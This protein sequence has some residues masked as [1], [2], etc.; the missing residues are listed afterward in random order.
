MKRRTV[1]V[2]AIGAALAGCIGSGT[3]TADNEADP[4]SESGSSA[5]SDEEIL[6][7]FENVLVD[8]GIEPMSIERAEGVLDV[9]YGSTGAS[10]ETVAAESELLGDLYAGAIDEGLSTDR[11]DALGRAPDDGADLYSFAIETGWVEAYLA[12]E[13]D[14]GEYLARIERTIELTEAG[15]EVRREE[16]IKER[17]AREK[18]REAT[19][20]VEGR[21]EEVE[22]RLDRDATTDRVDERLTDVESRS[23][24]DEPT[25][26][27]ELT[28]SDDP[29]D[30]IDD[31]LADDEDDEDDEDEDGLN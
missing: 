8:R 28:G 29:I 24:S 16:E 18:A 11:L 1:I 3:D 2:T 20:G 4:G 31:R 14:Q 26:R 13:I 19:E 6:G 9:V 23:N 12:D 5:P 25:D 21:V 30:R 27:D 10:A 7:L 17:E 15:E 22:E